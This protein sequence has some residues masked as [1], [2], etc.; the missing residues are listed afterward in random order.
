MTSVSVPAG[1][2][3]VGRGGRLEDAVVRLTMTVLLLFAFVYVTVTHLATIRKG[4]QGYLIGDWTISY[5]GGFVRRGFV[6]WVLTGLA[7]EA[8]SALVLLWGIQTGLYAVMFGVAIRWALLLP[9]PLRWVPLLLSPG[10]LLFP[11]HD[12]GGSHRK[13]II[14]LAGMFLLAEAV[15]AGRLVGSAAVLSLG[16]VAVGVL[17]HEANA[18]LVLP[19][20]LLLRRAATDGSLT[21]TRVRA[22]SFSF[23]AAATAGLI[24][25]ILAP[26]SLEQQ[27]AICADLVARGF[28][29]ALC[30]GSLEFLSQS[31][32]DQIGR[33]AGRMPVYMLYALPAV[34]ALAP[35]LLLDWARQNR[36]NLLLAIAP[37]APLFF[38]AVDWGRWIMLATVVATVLAVVGASRAGEVPEPLQIPLVLLFVT[39]WSIPHIGISG[40]DPG[41]LPRTIVDAGRWVLRT[42]G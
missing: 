36:H 10:F 25:S 13:E 3:S 2:R 27:R 1:G 41:A 5:A 35:F 8:S 34:F 42:L 22:A 38:V 31:L 20:I 7:P 19:F 24:V 39:G 21:P 29:A 30:R 14:V 16:L 23:M 15:R 9:Q 18:L 28:D 4:T 11:L 33:V 32:L 17:S 6:G 12:Y 26:G 37:I 40:L